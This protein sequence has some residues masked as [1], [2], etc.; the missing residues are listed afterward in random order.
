ME[1]KICALG[2]GKLVTGTSK[3]ETIKKDHSK[4]FK[5]LMKVNGKNDADKNGAA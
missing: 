5:L 4:I 1:G 3:R 2:F